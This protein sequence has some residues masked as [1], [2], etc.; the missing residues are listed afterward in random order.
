M[1]NAHKLDALREQIDDVDKN[2]IELIALR[3]KLVK[4][5]AEVKKDLGSGTFNPEREQFLLESR[6]DLAAMYDLTDGLIEAIPLLVEKVPEIITKLV[7]ALTTPDM[8]MK[9]IE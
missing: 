9:L 8:Q 5:A 7:L 1:E 4:E 3:L 6:H 2:L